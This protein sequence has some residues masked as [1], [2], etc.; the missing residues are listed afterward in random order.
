MTQESALRTDRQLKNIFIAPNRQ[1]RLVAIAVTVSITVIFAFF[2]F[3]L[4]IFSTLFINLAPLLPAGAKIEAPLAETLRWA[5]IGFA[6]GALF[7]TL[8]IGFSI[9]LFSHRIYGPM[10]AIRKHLS[11]L[12]SGDYDH[13][14]QLRKN[15]EFKEVAEDLNRLCE[16][17][18]EKTSK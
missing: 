8:V 6:F 12:L 17:L 13:R 1:I 9:A 16:K 4:W 10:V 11:A 3:E 2:A 15:D 5:W 14:T 18:G 7:C